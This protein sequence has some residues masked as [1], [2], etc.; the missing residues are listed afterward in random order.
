MDALVREEATCA[1]KRFDGAQA[2]LPD[3]DRRRLLAARIMAAVYRALLAKVERAG[4]GVL[5]RSPRVPAAQRA[6][7][8]LGLLLG[9]RLGRRG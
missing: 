4:S 7:I 9:D 6:L 2:L 5:D 8:A 1:R 3:V